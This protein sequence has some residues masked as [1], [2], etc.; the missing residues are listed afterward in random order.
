[1]RSGESAHEIKSQWLKS[2]GTVR[3]ILTTG[4]DLIVLIANIGIADALRPASLEAK[5][6]S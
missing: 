3:L 6:Q 4:D 2:D 1:M 5:S